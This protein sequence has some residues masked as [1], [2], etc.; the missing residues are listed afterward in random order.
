MI[1]YRVILVAALLASSATLP[2][3]AQ[4]PVAPRGKVPGVSPGKTI[5]PSPTLMPANPSPAAPSAPQAM[6]PTNQPTQAPVVPRAAVTP[7]ALV[8][9]PAVPP[10]VPAAPAAATGAFT[11]GLGLQPFLGG[12][13][14]ARLEYARALA[15]NL[16]SAA[17]SLV[18]L[19][20][21]TSGQ[22]M[23]GAT[24]PATLS[25]RERDRW[26]RCRDLYWD[27]TTFA[28]AA[29]SVRDGLPA[30]SPLYRAA[31]ALDTALDDIEA[32]AEC[33]N[34]A[35]MISAPDRWV[36]WT[37][38]YTGAARHFYA[39]WYAQMREAHEKDRAFVIAFNATLPAGQGAIPVPPG[40]PRTPPYAGAG[41][42]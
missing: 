13:D 32:L 9:T 36:Q 8:T 16:D 11:A 18:N 24:G 35:S 12:G 20:R 28:A 21:G 10:S 27:F 41:V 29:Q 4:V 40:L 34:V 42:R 33:D 26:T 17:V 25:G 22:P 30:T 3:G 31:A 15:R 5:R 14:A 37:E 7:Q 1:G 23:A 38:E 39:D 19:Y 2:L 6:P